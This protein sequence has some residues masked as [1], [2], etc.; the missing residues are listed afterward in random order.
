MF[1]RR[2][3]PRRRR[4]AVALSPTWPTSIA[5]HRRVHRLREIAT[6]GRP[7]STDEQSLAPLDRSPKPVARRSIPVWL[8]GGWFPPS[9]SQTRRVF[10]PSPGPAGREGRARDQTAFPQ[11]QHE[12]D[13]ELPLAGAHHSGAVLAFGAAGGRARFWRAADNLGLWTLYHPPTPSSA[14]SGNSTRMAVQLGPNFL[15]SWAG[16]PPLASATDWG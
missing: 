2:T 15:W 4:V 10:R 1:R 13:V 7:V 12:A 3:P 6:T 16:P 5:V 9:Q 14:A 8:S 11:R